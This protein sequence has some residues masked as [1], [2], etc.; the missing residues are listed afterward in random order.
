MRRRGAIGA[1]VCLAIVCVAGTAAAAP[2][3]TSGPYDKWL[4]E[5]EREA[6]AAGISQQAIAAAA[7]YLLTI[8]AS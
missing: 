7:P 5:F 2:C 8:S 1:I 6:M 4:A 3:R